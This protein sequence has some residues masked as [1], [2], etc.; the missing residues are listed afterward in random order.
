MLKF[1]PFT[2]RLD[3]FE[4]SFWDLETSTSIVP[5]NSY[6][7]RF[8]SDIG[9]GFGG[10]AGSPLT[11][12][13][14]ETADANANSLLLSLPEGG[15]VNVPVFVIGDE[16]ALYK[17]L[18]LFNGF[19]NPT[20]AI[21][22]DDATKAIYFQHDG[23]DG[24]IGVTSGT[25]NSNVEYPMDCREK[26]IKIMFDHAKEAVVFNM[27]G[28]YPQPTN[29]EKYKVW[30]ANSLEILKFCLSSSPKVIFRHH[31]RMKDF[32]LIIFK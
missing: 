5:K 23:T 2:N 25:L 22:N 10:T 26:A 31:Y 32:T 14:W 27:A 7:P 11:Q 1:N 17:D 28:G 12:L 13:L 9:F 29:K 19:T 21:L 15:A 4:S 20:L 6:K 3:Y 18:G 30:Y 24:T 16:T 8:P